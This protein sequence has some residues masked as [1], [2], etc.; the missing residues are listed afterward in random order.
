MSADAHVEWLTQPTGRTVWLDDGTEQPETNWM[1]QAKPGDRTGPYELAPVQLGG[2]PVWVRFGVQPAKTV[3]T[4]VLMLA[5]SQA[6]DA[7]GETWR[8]ANCTCEYVDVGVG[9]HMKVAENPECPVCTEFGYA[10]WAYKNGTDDEKA[11]ATAYL[12]EVLG[13][14]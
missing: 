13:S 5:E 10:A 4:R 12:D 8:R 2:R 14:L 6:G 1:A 7:H 3:L 11:A 9:P